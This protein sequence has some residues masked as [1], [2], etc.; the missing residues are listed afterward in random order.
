MENTK[1]SLIL[2][3]FIRLV[4][5]ACMII[6]GLTCYEGSLHEMDDG[7]YVLYRCDR[8]VSLIYNAYSLN[9][10]N[11]GRHLN[12]VIVMILCGVHVQ[13]SYLIGFHCDFQDTMKVINS[14]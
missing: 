8:Y 11:I 10:R 4:F 2:L 6:D 12:N 13:D 9:T 3:P 1:H 5:L 7:F 14:G